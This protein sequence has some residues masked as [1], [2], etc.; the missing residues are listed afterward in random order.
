MNGDLLSIFKSDIV[1]A[2]NDSL[3]N[4]KIFIDDKP[5]EYYINSRASQNILALNWCKYKRIE[6]Q[7]GSQFGVQ[8]T[9]K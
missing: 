6:I 8:L 7:N 1:V 2:L 4:L 3:I 9:D 5:V